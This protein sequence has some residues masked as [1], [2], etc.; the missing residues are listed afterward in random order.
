[1]NNS[2]F[3]DWPEEYASKLVEPSRAAELVRPGD[4]IVIPIGA[5]TPALSQAVWERRAE[6]SGID[7]L[8]CAPYHDPGWFGGYSHLLPADRSRHGTVDHGFDGDGRRNGC[9][10]DQRT[11]NG[12]NGVYIANGRS[13]AIRQWITP[14]AEF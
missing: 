1:M 11:S 14:N 4:T 3:S 7:I 13:D 5:I 2:R 6:L 9:A 8:T 12:G 10:N